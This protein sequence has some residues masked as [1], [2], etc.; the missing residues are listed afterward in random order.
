MVDVV[1]LGECMAVL[2]PPEP[3]T[4][5]DA[6]TLSVEIGGAEGNLSIALS[7]LG[8]TTRLIGRVGDDPFGRRI[9]TILSQEGVDTTFL[10]TDNGAPTGLYMREWLPD[11][12]R[13]VYYY[14]V[15]SAG[16]R[17]SPDDVPEAA[18]EGVRI[19]HL[20]GI[21]PAL[22]ASCAAAVARAVELAH[23]MGALVAFDPNY[24]HRLWD[25]TTA[26]EALI[27]LMRQAD[28]LLIGHED[29]QVLLGEGTDAELLQRGAALGARVVV[30][31]C[32]ERGALA[33]T[34]G[35]V[36]S[37]PAER[38]EQVIDPVGAGDGFDAGFLAGWLEGGDLESMLRLGARVGAAAVATLG[39]YKGYPR[40][41]GS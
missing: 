6:S 26:Q 15:G 19:V 25:P 14:R 8:H 30:L 27:P 12:A 13:R 21:T 3:I 16:S 32:A 31:K 41:T 28:L 34:E 10:I 38:V 4:L 7:R 5:D 18:F 9:Q 39:D 23:R 24:R 40:R 36:V 20:T 22:S 29:A 11:G 37:V 2:Y 35:R 17:L 1:A 33:L